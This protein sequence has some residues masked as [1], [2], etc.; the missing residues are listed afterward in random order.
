MATN[1]TPDNEFL[2]FLL[3][4]LDEDEIDSGS[5]ELVEEMR[6]GN[7]QI[8]GLYDYLREYLDKEF[9]KYKQREYW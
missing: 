3:R 8:K 6:A 7:P 9:E 5:N 1:F 2:D 4:N